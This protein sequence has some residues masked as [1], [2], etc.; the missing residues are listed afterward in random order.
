MTAGIMRWAVARRLAL[1]CVV[2]A[3]TAQ[4]QGLFRDTKPLLV[5][6][7]TDLRAVVRDRDSTKFAPHPATLTYRTDSTSPPRSFPVTLRARGHFRR[8]ARNCGFPPLKLEFARADARTTLFQGNDELKIATTCRPGSADYEQYV[9]A[10]YALY[11]HY[12]AVSPRH[13][14]T[15]LARI[16]YHDSTRASDDVV[17]WAFFVEEDREVAKRFASVVDTSRGA[18]FRDLEPRQLAITSLFQYLVANTDWSISALHNVSLLRDSTGQVHPVA[19]DFDWSGAVNARYARPDARL[20]IQSTTVRLYRGPCLDAA[21]WRPTL[22]RFLAA[23]PAIEAVYDSLPGLDP[24]RA[25]TMRAYLGEFYRTI[26]DPKLAQ[27]ALGS[28]CLPE[29]N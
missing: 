14:R 17:S 10:E 1:L 22:A 11:R 3:A 19:F 6:I 28:T 5:T 23:R 20:E 21:A 8:Q 12:Q 9:L 2:L 13:F 26:S 4:A 18:L 15:R 25:R 16:T 29:G 27:R 7:T 24:Q